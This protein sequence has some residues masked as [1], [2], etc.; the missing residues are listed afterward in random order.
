MSVLSSKSKKTKILLEGKHHHRNVQKEIQV[1]SQNQDMIRDYRLQFEY[2]SL[3]TYAPDGMIVVPQLDNLLSW[4]GM[5]FVREGEYKGANL[6]FRL[7]IPPNY[8]ARG[9]DVF[10]NDEV[11]HIL[12]NP[13]T[14][15]LNI[16]P[17]FPVWNPRRHNIVGILGYIYRIFEDCHDIEVS[18][19]MNTSLMTLYLDSKHDYL[20]IVRKTVSHSQV[21]VFHSEPESPLKARYGIFSCPRQIVEMDESD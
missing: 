18:Y 2:Q 7:E 10:F 3:K 5:H 13:E 16:E 19:A 21:N 1:H 6:K 12:I 17:M 4:H 11:A 20:E 15:Q 9:P 14:K 8:P